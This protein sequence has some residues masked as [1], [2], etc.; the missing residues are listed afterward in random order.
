MSRPVQVQLV[1]LADGPPTPLD[2]RWL[3]SYDPDT[4]SRG[5]GGVMLNCTIQ[6]TT[7]R[8]L[9]KTFPSFVEAH[10]YVYRP[11]RKHPLRADGKPNRPLSAWT[12]SIEQVDRRSV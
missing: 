9:A 12:L 1:A 3:V 7:E 6:V 4:P 5:P 11:S 2:G 10:R 8:A